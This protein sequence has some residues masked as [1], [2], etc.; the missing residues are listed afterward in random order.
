MAIVDEALSRLRQ[1]AVDL[2]GLAQQLRQSGPDPAP[3]PIAD[4]LEASARDAA[5]D[6]ETLAILAFASSPRDEPRPPPAAP[7]AVS[8]VA[9]T[10]APAVLPRVPARQASLLEETV[11]AHDR[12]YATS[13]NGLPAHRAGE[14]PDQC[15][16]CELFAVL[17]NPSID[18][19]SY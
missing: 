5:Q 9:R 6:V 16:A 17:L 15:E 12:D 2:Q 10:P 7:V 19:T 1:H 8:P 11:A 4:R 3:S 14:L 13:R 18:T